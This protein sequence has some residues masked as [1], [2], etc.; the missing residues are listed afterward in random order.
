MRGKRKAIQDDEDDEEIPS[1][2][3]D[4]GKGEIVDNEEIESEDEDEDDVGGE[5][6]NDEEDD[7]DDESEE[8]EFEEDVDEHT[9][10]QM[11]VDVL[12]V[13]E[14]KENIDNEITK[15]RRATPAE[16]EPHELIPENEFAKFP[17]KGNKSAG[18]VL[19]YHDSS[20]GTAHT[21]RRWWRRCM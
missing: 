20:D 11:L 4:V 3:E 6:A 10:G 12:D 15:K 9:H 14:R 7:E 13:L 21:A 8:D 19:V 17:D 2:L 16:Q 18:N 1:D 5:N